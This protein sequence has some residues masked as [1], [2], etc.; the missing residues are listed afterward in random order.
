MNRKSL[1]SLIVCGVGFYAIAFFSFANGS[2]YVIAVNDA[3]SETVGV[4]KVELLFREM[5]APLSIKPE[6]QFF[7]S[8]R[9]LKMTNSGKLDAEAGRIIEVAAEYE[10]LILVPE[11]MIQH[12]I[13]F[14]CLRA[15]HCTGQNNP[16]Y[17]LSGG[18]EAG[19]KFCREFQLNCLIDQS[20]LFLSKAFSSDAVDVLIGSRAI[21][22]G[23][24]C[25]S[26]LDEVYYQESD[27]MKII[28][29]HLVHKQHANLVER[30]AQSIKSM[31]QRG[32]FDAFLAQTSAM[33]E[34]CSLRLNKINNN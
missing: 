14:F 5:Y 11:P 25:Q 10:N 17:A 13:F 2:N 3:Y 7:P 23:I 15:E 27:Q 34:G 18:F 8:R 28:S 30:L 22:L 32:F 16:R 4:E 26:E 21:V 20:P 24:L 19:K 6:I 12:P 9:G 31:Q 29:Y 33:P 1:F